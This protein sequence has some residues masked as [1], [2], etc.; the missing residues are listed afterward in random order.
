MVTS[1]PRFPGLCR[2]TR[3]HPG[4]APKRKHPIQVDG[5]FQQG[6]S[7]FVE[8]CGGRNVGQ[9][10]GLVVNRDGHLAQ[11]VL[12]HAGVVSAEEQLGSAVQLDT[13]IGL[14]AAPITTID[15]GQT[16]QF[17]ECRHDDLFSQQAMTSGTTS[18]HGVLF[19]ASQW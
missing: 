1:V 11:L 16:G 7:V 9:L 8:G 14:C 5:V 6:G 2:K 3:K 19:R 12:V 4:Q 17:C 13:D 18:F 15:R 10:L